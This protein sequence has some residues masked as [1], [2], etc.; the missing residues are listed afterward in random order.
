MLSDEDRRQVL[1]DWSRPGDPSALAHR[2][3]HQL[4]LDQAARTPDATAVECGDERLTYR[5]LAE[6]AAALA[7]V[8]RAHGVGPETK[9]G[10]TGDGTPGSSSVCSPS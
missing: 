6:Q 7:L 1:T 3:V 10:L 5:E 8:L 2:G 4:V 9:V